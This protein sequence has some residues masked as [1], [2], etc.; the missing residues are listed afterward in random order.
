[1][2]GPKLTA[3]ALAGCPTDTAETIKN[4][5]LSGLGSLLLDTE[6]VDARNRLSSEELADA[7]D[8]FCALLGSLKEPERRLEGT[9]ELVGRDLDR[10][11]VAD[12]SELIMEL[13][14][15]AL[16]TVVTSLEPELA[17]ALIQTMTPVAH[18]RLF[19][20]VPPN[21]SKR[22]LDALEEASPLGSIELTRCAQL[23][24]QKVLAEFV[25]RAKPLGKAIP[26]PARLRELLTAILSRE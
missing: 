23:F 7:Q 12:L 5:A 9:E 10:K 18:D 26:L 2:A 25:P 6:I 8:A 11:L 24:A 20:S 17:A 19:A 14:D 21:R 15:R 13:D 4:T 22:I 16:R 3:A 1:M